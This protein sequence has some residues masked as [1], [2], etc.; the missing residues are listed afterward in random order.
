MTKRE[1]RLL[2][3]AHLRLKPDTILWD[4]GSGTG[5]IPVETGLLCPQGQIIAVERDEDVAKLIRTNCDRFALKNVQIIQGS[6]PECL[7]D[8]P[9]VPERVCIEGGKAVKD[10]LH[11]VW[12][13]LQ[14]EGRVVATATSLENL[15]TISAT[16]AELQVR[17][18]EV[19]QSVVNRLEIRG[20]EQ[21]FAAVD[22]IFI[23]SGEKAA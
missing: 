9:Y 1:T 17:S 23:L 20:N 21:I 15:Y 18:V 13:H 2:L 7:A 3:I 8:L 11:A 16:F 5:T 19:V 10:I 14:P 12:Q 6:A 22:P 4:I